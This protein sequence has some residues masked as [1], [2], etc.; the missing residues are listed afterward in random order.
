VHVNFLAIA[1]VWLSVSGC[2]GM[3]ILSVG[4]L[5]RMGSKV[6]Q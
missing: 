4:V 5:L 2:G 1:S 3:S 6:V